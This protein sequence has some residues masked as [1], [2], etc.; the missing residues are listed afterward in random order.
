MRRRV[1]HSM[2]AM[3]VWTG[4]LSTLALAAQRFDSAEIIAR[5]L[6]VRRSVSYP[7]AAQD[8]GIEGTVLVEF[9]ID[10]LCTINNKRVVRGL[11]YGLDEAA[12]KVIDRKF[13]DAL[14]RALMPCSPDTIVFPITF[15]LR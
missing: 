11:G 9:T 5:N 10:R 2:R 7:Q 1:L 8:A 4:V 12:L 15:K 13:E 6:L 3:A 14:T